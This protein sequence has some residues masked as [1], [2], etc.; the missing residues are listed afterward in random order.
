MGISWVAGARRVAQPWGGSW[1]HAGRQVGGT[2]PQ[3]VKAGRAGVHVEPGHPQGVVVE[4]HGGGPLVVLVLEDGSARRPPLVG[5]G[6]ELGPELLVEAADPG[7]A[8]G[9]VGG[10]GQIPRLGEPVA[11]LG[12]VAPVQVGH[13]RDR[14]SVGTRRRGERRAHIPARGAARRVGPVAAK[15]AVSSRAIDRAPGGWA[16]LP[17]PTPPSAMAADRRLSR[18]R[19]YTGPVGGFVRRSSGLGG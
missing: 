11:L 7:E 15:C 18:N 1:E 13:D 14:P 19:S 2:A 10:G 5:L 3:Q 6:L 8:G 9:N 17:T 4:P 12:A 16:R